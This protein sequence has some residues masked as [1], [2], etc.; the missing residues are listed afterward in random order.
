MRIFYLK[1]ILLLCGSIWYFKL[2]RRVLLNYIFLGYYIIQYLMLFFD[3]SQ[4][5]VAPVL[6]VT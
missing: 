4:E 3:V 1:S 5:I 6:K 2:Q